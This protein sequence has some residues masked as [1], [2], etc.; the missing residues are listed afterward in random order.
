MVRAD[1]A[2]AVAYL[3][4]AQ[5][6]APEPEPSAS[7]RDGPWGAAAAVSAL[8]IGVDFSWLLLG[9]RKRL[10]RGGVLSI[11]ELLLIAVAMM[12]TLAFAAAIAVLFIDGWLLHPP[13]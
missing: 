8:T 9:V 2:A 10:K 5:S 4:Q 7:R 12:V 11:V 13:K 3:K 1:T 6:E